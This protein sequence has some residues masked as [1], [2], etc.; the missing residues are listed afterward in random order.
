MITFQTTKGDIQIELDFDNAPI[1]AKNFE[2]Y[3]KAGFFTGTIFHRVIKGFM[4]QGG[5]FDEDMNQ[6]PTNAPIEN[7][8]K[9]GLK[10]E[11]YTLSM[12]R[13]M[14]P[15]SATGQFFLNTSN[16]SFLDYPGQDGWGYAVFGKAV[17]GMDVIDAIESVATGNR[18]GHADVPTENIVI[19]NTIVD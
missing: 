1:S 16:N 17:S 14:D 15:H 6:K 4:I 13:T 19:T 2:D 3:A 8:A 10:N 9:N 18:S 5:G 7:E 11:K 12:A